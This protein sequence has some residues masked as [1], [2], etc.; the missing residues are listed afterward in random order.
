MRIK[1]D[2]KANW[3]RNNNEIDGIRRM[4]EAEVKLTVGYKEDKEIYINSIKKLGAKY[5][6][7]LEHTD[8][9][10]NMPDGLRNFAETDEALRIRKSTEYNALTGKKTD[11]KQSCDITYKGPK[12]DKI[13]KSRIEFV[14][15][16]LDPD[17]LDEI[18]LTLGFRRILTVKKERILYHLEYEGS[19]IEILIDKIQHLDG[20]FS[21]FEIMTST[22][23]EMADA[24]KT[25]FKLMNKLGYSISDSITLSYLELVI[26]KLIEQGKYNI[27]KG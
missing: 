20:Y 17:I 14:C 18:L 3:K 23:E 26:K 24:K 22:R 4:Y 1:S 8:I 15:N 25:I 19:S 6:I 2:L 9:Y 11:V 16:I 21:E 12:L 13:T 27:K 7:N 10:Y 5:R